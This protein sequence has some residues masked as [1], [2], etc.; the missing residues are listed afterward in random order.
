MRETSKSFNGDTSSSR[1]EVVPIR[2]FGVVESFDPCRYTHVDGHL[3]GVLIEW[4]AG[5]VCN[6][7]DSVEARRNHKCIHHGLRAHGR[8]CL[9]ANGCEV[10][11]SVLNSCFGQRPEPMTKI[12]PRVGMVVCDRI[13][14]EVLLV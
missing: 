10:I 3:L 11:P 1:D 6:P 7:S 5:R 12:N 4:N 13:Q 2:F 14:V 9:I 8:A